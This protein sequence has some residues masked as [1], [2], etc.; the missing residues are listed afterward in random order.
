MKNINIKNINKAVMLM[1]ALTHAD[2]LTDQELA[3][4]CAQAFV[5][6]RQDVSMQILAALNNNT[7]LNVVKLQHDT[8]LAT[9]NKMKNKAFAE[10]YQKHHNQ[11]GQ[12]VDDIRARNAALTTAFRLAKHDTENMMDGLGLG[13]A[14]VLAHHEKEQLALVPEVEFR[15]ITQ[16]AQKQLFAEYRKTRDR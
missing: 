10:Y 5:S 15:L 8:V 16:E 9:L 6:A 13:F 3:L 2:G 1:F 4:G 7:Q 14:L 12:F 11:F